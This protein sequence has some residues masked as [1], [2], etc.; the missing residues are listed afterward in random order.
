MATPLQEQDKQSRLKML[1][2]K[3]KEQGYLTY[4]EVNDHIPEGIVDPESQ[5]IISNLAPDPFQNYAAAKAFMG[6]QGI[7]ETSLTN[8]APLI[9]QS[10]RAMIAH[11]QELIILAD[12]S[13]F[14]HV[15]SLTLCPVEKA[16]RIITTKEADPEL[17]S[18]LAE[19]GIKI[20]K[21]WL[22]KA[23]FEQYKSSRR[24]YIEPE[25]YFRKHPRLH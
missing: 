7:T 18:R 16:S 8:S 22:P 4:A 15:G 14:G 12:D 1:I 2:A 21:V 3:G 19:K 13:K 5:L 9:I 10:E 25:Q 24:I 23:F 11:S 17:T 6:I 20:I